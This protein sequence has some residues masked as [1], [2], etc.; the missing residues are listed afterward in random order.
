MDDQRDFSE[1]DFEQA[2][3]LVGQR[4]RFQRRAKKASELINYLLARKGYAQTQ[5]K[6]DVDESWRLIVGDKWKNRTVA[7]NVR[8]GVLEVVVESSAAHQ[9]LKFIKKSLLVSMQEKMPQNKIRDIKFRV[10]KVDKSR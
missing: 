9:Q 10:G 8:R 2:N 1:L 4:Q 5:S 3:D 7:G 6:N